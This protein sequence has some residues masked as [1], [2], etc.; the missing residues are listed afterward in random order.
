M[1][2]GTTLNIHMLRANQEVNRG[3][4]HLKLEINSILIDFKENER[5]LELTQ[6][7][8]ISFYKFH[9]YISKFNSN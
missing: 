4:F 3:D 6:V 5:N 8:K 2:A 9:R 1:K 7:T